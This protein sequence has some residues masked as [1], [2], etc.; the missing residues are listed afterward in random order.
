MLAY[1]L[2]CILAQ[3]PTCILA[4]LLFCLFGHLLIACLFSCLFTSFLANFLTCLLAHLLTCLLAYLG[5]CLHAS[6]LHWV[7]LYIWGDF[8]SHKICFAATWKNWDLQSSKEGVRQSLFKQFLT[9]FQIIGFVAQ[10]FEASKFLARA[11]EGTS[12]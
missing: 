7:E 8:L 6:L 11:T 12:L 10:G 2:T 3:F 1:L 9:Y 5:S 4:Y